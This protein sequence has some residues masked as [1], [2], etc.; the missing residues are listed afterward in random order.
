MSSESGL[1][2]RLSI[3]VQTSL[4]M[5]LS[6]W[7]SHLRGDTMINNLALRYTNSPEGL[8]PFFNICFLNKSLHQYMMFGR[9][10]KK[11]DNCVYITDHSMFSMIMYEIPCLNGIIFFSKVKIL[12]GQKKKCN[13]AMIFSF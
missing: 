6:S 4:E 8:A 3:C 7:T 11:T 5:H 13:E 2:E 10:I 1:E 9:Q 12:G